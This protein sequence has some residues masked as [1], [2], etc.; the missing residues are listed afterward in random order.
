MTLIHPARNQVVSGPLRCGTNQHRGF[1][2]CESLLVEIIPGQLADVVPE[3]QI[4]LHLQF[5]E[6]QI[7]VLQSEIHIDV[8]VVLDVDRRCL[9]SGV[10]HQIGG[11][12]FNVS[13]R[14]IRVLRRTFSHRS[15]DA[16]HVFTSQRLR[17]LKGFFRNCVVEND[18]R[19]SGLVPQVRK[20]QTAEASLLGDP[21]V[22]CDCFADILLRENTA[23]VGSLQ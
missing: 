14:Q 5:P 21:A 3:G 22:E 10:Q 15:G 16:D 8:V 13:G 23:H 18:L 19:N 9:C 20:N 7:A 6:I 2:L 12:Y 4:P 11:Q 17:Q 1:H